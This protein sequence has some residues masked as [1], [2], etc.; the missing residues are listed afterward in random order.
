MRVKLHKEVYEITQVKSEDLHKVLELLV[1][2]AA[3]LKTKR[4]K[5]WS[6]YLTDLDGNKEEILRSIEN[7]ATYLVES[8][9]QPISTF[10]IENIP[11]EW[12]ME[13]WGEEAKD[14]ALYLHRLVVHRNH[15]GKGIGAALLDWIEKEAQEAGKKIIRFDCIG[16][17]E[18]L[19]HYYQKR[20]S[21]KEVT[22]IHG[23]HSKYEII[24]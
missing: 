15:A 21:L 4:T 10:T 2:A 17:N 8:E 6:Y 11:S 20:Y 7:G 12:D 19:N 1:D 16:S 24:L 18:G 14:E 23:S 3:W 13:L 22:Q 5:Q 9:G